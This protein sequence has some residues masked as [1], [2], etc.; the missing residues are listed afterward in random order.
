MLRITHFADG[1]ATLD[2]HFAHFS[3]T[4]PQGRM[5]ALARNILDRAARATSDLRAFPW[6]QFNT[7]HQCP[8]RDV[9]QRQRVTHLDRRISTGAQDRTGLHAF[10]RN[11]ITPIA[12]GINQKRDVGR[13]IGVVFDALYRRRDTIL[14]ALEVD[15]PVA[16]FMPA[17]LMP[18]RNPTVVVAPSFACLLFDERTVWLALV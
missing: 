8:Y 11:D 7:V 4:Q 18:D 16:L 6:F 5:R 15:D 13:P 12:V 3:R 2:R 14:I 10:W 1:R 9:P 17:A